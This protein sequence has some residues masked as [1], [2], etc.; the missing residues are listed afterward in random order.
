MS[1]QV[2]YEVF[3]CY[4]QPT[5]PR[6]VRVLTAKSFFTIAKLG[7]RAR[8]GCSRSIL[9]LLVLQKFQYALKAGW[10]FA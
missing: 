10:S 3:V 1:P 9:D 2:G 4:F 6:T 5:F 8:Q 7:I